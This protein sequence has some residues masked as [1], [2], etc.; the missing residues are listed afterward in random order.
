MA[1]VAAAAIATWPACAT[2]EV[3][4]APSGEAANLDF[5]LKDMDGKEVHLASFRGKP[6]ILN[7]WATWCGPCKIEI[8]AFV[9]LVEQYRQQQ[10]T[11]L[12]VSV[13]DAPE[14][15]KK[16]AADYKM[17]YPVLVGLGQDA[18]QETYDAVISIPVTWFIRPDGTILRKHRGPATKEWFESQV[19]ALLAPAASEAH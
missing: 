2:S 12:G 18:L 13:D 5:T 14:D 3:E 16:F 17:N 7:F 1:A 8:P 19:K 9:E 11:V 4:P 10:L 6:L 15:L